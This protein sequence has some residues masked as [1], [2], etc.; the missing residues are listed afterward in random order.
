M[1]KTD[2]KNEL[3]NIDSSLDNFL[4]RAVVPETYLEDKTKEFNSI[5]EK[6]NTFKEFVDL[7]LT[8]NVFKYSQGAYELYRKIYPQQ[9]WYKLR[10]FLGDDCNKCLSDSGSLKIGNDDFALFIGN[11]YGDGTTRYAI[12]DYEPEWSNWF[13]YVQNFFSV[14]KDNSIFVYGYDCGDESSRTETSLSTGNYSARA[15]EGLVLITKYSN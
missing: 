4:L 12:F 15:Y 2:I 9:F 7:Y 5:C 11:G 1:K 13:G 3:K 6:S 8:S 14:K 10:E